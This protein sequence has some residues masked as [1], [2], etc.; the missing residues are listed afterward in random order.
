MPSARSL[1]LA[2]LL[3]LAAGLA[4]PA[5]GWASGPLDKS[6]QS[7]PRELSLA[8]GG[9]LRIKPLAE[10]ESLRFDP[11]AAREITI[12]PP[13]RLHSGATSQRIATLA[14]DAMEIRITVDRAQAEH[15]RFGLKLFAGNGH[16]GLPLLVQP[17]T[18]TLR[19]G[20][21]SAPFAVAD[22]PAG[23]DLE[24]R[25]YVDQ[26]LVEVFANQ[27]QALVAAHLDWRAANGL[28]GYTFGAPTTIKTLELWRL[29][30]ANQG[31]FRAQKERVWE[32]RTE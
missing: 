1:A 8:P 12:N 7:L 10:L 11:V 6:I 13:S 18:A 23:E 14:A 9:S 2:L 30:P 21:T 15:K 20:G 29:K 27:R 24:L 22:L 16:E 4:L 31:Y 28:D 25:I 3:V 17:E 26:Y 19:L 5:T 32:P